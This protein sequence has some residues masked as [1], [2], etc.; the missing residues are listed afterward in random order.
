MK[1]N[2]LK[3]LLCSF[4]L[5]AGIEPTK[6]AVVQPEEIAESMES[7]VPCMTY[8]TQIRNTL[9]IS[10][11]G[12]AQLVCNVAGVYGSV[13]R[14]VITANLQQYQN[15]QWIT[16]ETYAKDS[17]SY[18]VTLN[19]SCQVSKGYTYRVVANVQAYTSSASEG[20]TVVSREVRY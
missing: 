19:N 8:I 7:V 5:V 16:I 10:N 12:N 17:N 6:G 9:S 15:G 14:I 11:S 18:D 20:R 2:I 3:I 1:K 4:I 13:T